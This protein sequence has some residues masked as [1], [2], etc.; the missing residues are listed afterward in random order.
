MDTDLRALERKL[1]QDPG[2]LATARALYR[3][4]LRIAPEACPKCYKPGVRILS[5]L[6]VCCCMSCHGGSGGVRVV[7]TIAGMACYV[8]PDCPWRPA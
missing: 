4:R 8:C 6:M 1:A 5:G 7:D 2:D 3:G